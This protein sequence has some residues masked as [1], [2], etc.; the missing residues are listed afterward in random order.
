[1]RVGVA[2]W[3]GDITAAANSLTRG[4]AADLVSWRVLV[5]VCLTG[6]GSSVSLETDPVVAAACLLLVLVS[7]LAA[8]TGSASTAA[9]STGLVLLLV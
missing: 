1:M 8:G 5:L 2:R 9:S 4:L 3:E 6:P 7:R